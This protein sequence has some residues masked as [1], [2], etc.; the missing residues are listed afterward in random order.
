[1]NLSQQIAL[2]QQHLQVLQ[3][4][5]FNHQLAWSLGE[6]IRQRAERQHLALA[7]EINVNHQCI[8]SYAMAG[9]TPEN[10]DW[11]RRKRNVVELLNISSYEAGLMLQQ[12]QTTLS[13]RYGVN[14]R[15][16]AALGGGFPLQIRQSGVIGS[17]NVSGAPHLDDHEFLL[18]TLSEFIGLPAG[19][20]ESL[21]ELDN[22]L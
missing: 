2:C 8:F 3:F 11:L 1:M 17:I 10:Q 15:D 4:S 7:I 9:T 14:P 22:T 5:H 19:S 18:L 12:R 20:V 13:E 6:S 21:R 16:Y